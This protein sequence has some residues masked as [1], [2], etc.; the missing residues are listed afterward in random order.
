MA[1]NFIQKAIKK[2]GA[3]RKT[4]WVPMGKKVSKSFMDRIM[5][6][7]EGKVIKNPTKTW[8]KSIKVTP[9]LKK[10]VS[11]AETLNKLRK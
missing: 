5:K 9:L 7:T 1:K 6:G 2:P 10:R 4:L 8:K 3:L 11:L